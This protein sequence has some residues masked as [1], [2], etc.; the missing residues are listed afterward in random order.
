VEHA[1]SAYDFA[2]SGGGGR[3]LSGSAPGAKAQA[4]AE[5]RGVNA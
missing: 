5:A 3:S 2:T 4:D 1:E